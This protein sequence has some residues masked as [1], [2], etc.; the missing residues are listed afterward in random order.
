ML[1]TRQGVRVSGNK[2]EKEAKPIQ[3]NLLGQP[4]P[5]DTGYQTLRGPWMK[6]L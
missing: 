3:D 6:V 4:W 2:E 5:S 1:F